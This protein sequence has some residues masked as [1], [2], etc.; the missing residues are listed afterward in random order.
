MKIATVLATAALIAAGCNEKPPAPEA[1]MPESVAPAASGESAPVCIAPANREVAVTAP[2][3]KDILEAYVVGVDC[4]QAVLLLTLRKADGV[5][6][7]SHSVRATDTWAFVPASDDTPIVPAEGM[8][9]FL[10]DVL[11]NVRIEKTGEAPDWP[12]GA[13][14]PQDPSGLYHTTPL[15]RDAYI[16]LRRKNVPMLCVQAEMGTSY[17]AAYDPEF[18]DVANTFYSSSS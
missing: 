14:R 7:W 18:A 4:G 11:K 3:A 1:G 17:C 10:S 12:E 8:K 2:E 13:E 5:L 15:P 16:V 9:T 6:L